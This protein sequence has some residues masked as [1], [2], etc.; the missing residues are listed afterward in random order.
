MAIVAAMAAAHDNPVK[1]TQTLRA[2]A[3]LAS[4]VGA[5]ALRLPAASFDFANGLWLFR[6]WTAVAM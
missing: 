2:V 3:Q 4:G 5:P 1:R 6:R